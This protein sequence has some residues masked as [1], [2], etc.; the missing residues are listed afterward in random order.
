M[1]IELT[2]RTKDPI[3]DSAP[4]KFSGPGGGA[5]RGPELI[6][7]VRGTANT[8]LDLIVE[9]DAG[10]DPLSAARGV[11]LGMLLSVIIW[12]PIMLAVWFLYQQS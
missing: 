11:M 3:T 8:N 9:V 4:D 6:P 10:T 1:Q 12:V 7:L 5:D 2:D